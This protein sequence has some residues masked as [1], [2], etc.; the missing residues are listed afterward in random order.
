VKTLWFIDTSERD[1][2]PEVP[3]FQFMEQDLR[4][5]PGP[6]AA[7]SIEQQIPAAASVMFRM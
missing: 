5:V 1:S 3:I 6:D 2:A 4:A 7:G